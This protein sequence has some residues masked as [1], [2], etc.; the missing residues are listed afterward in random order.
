MIKFIVD[1]IEIII[2]FKILMWGIRH[3]FKIRKNKK[4]KRSIIK[5]LK[6]LISNRI[7][8]QLN[9]M[10]RNQ[11]EKLSIKSEDKVVTIKSY[12]LKKITN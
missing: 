12:K 7:H 4:Y 6:I 8:Y 9:K 2:V 3:I 11:R 1:I 5:K 10:L